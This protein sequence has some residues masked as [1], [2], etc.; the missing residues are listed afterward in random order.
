[1]VDSWS[2]TPMQVNVKGAV[3]SA[4]RAGAVTNH[5][6]YDSLFIWS[7]LWVEVH[8]GRVFMLRLSYLYAYVS[9]GRTVAYMYSTVSRLKKGI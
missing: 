5:G 9:D 2:A 7:G 6:G 3:R 8:T 4:P 1:M